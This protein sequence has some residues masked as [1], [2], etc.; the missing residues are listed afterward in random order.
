MA[1]SFSK[2]FM[3]TPKADKLP[4]LSTASFIGNG[5][6]MALRLYAYFERSS[7][8]QST[9]YDGEVAS[10]PLLIHLYNDDLEKMRTETIDMLV[11][12]YERYFTD[13]SIEVDFIQDINSL[14]NMQ[15]SGTMKMEN[16][17]VRLNTQSDL[18]RHLL[19]AI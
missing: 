13:V 5:D 17:L 4:T 3:E 19:N 10:L 16:K 8:K 2:L 9:I 14:Y 1:D 15:V 11:K 12:M 7:F 18:S 6:K